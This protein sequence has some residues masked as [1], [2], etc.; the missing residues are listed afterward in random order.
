L[1]SVGLAQQPGAP[2]HPPDARKGTRGASPLPGIRASRPWP[3]KSARAF[4]LVRMRGQGGRTADL[5]LFRGLCRSMQDKRPTVRSI[6]SVVDVS[7]VCL[8]LEN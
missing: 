3:E 4:W 7:L 5:P 2:L 1:D 8:K 6:V